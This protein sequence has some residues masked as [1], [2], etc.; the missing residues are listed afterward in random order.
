M[1]MRSFHHF[2]LIIPVKGRAS[3][4]SY[5]QDWG[6]DTATCSANNESECAHMVK[7]ERERGDEL[8]YTI[9]SLWVSICTLSYRYTTL[10]F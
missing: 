2:I 4:W 5:L 9:L 3:G 8:T 6:K 1:I 10:F 7:R